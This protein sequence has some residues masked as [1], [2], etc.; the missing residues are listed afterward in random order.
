MAIGSA[1]EM[2]V[3]RATL[4]DGIELDRFLLH[5]SVLERWVLVSSNAGNEFCGDAFGR[6][7]M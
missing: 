5:K 7:F 2:G 3:V 6:E 4:L 1:A